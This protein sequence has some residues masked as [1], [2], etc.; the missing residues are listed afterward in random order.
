MGYRTEFEGLNVGTG[1]N[2]SSV[3]GNP[4]S[5]DNFRTFGLVKGI[6][7]SSMQIEGNGGKQ[8]VIGEGVIQIS[9]KGLGIIID[10]KF[11]IIDSHVPTLGVTKDI[12]TNGLGISVQECEIKHGDEKQDLDK[13][14]CSWFTAVIQR[15]YHTHYTPRLS[16]DHSTEYS[17]T[18][19]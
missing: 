14:S 2:R 4:Q 17:A 8:G 7:P 12:W 10:V 18:R 13:I 5:E 15:I 19:R 9:F 3:I 11:K 1:E 16:C 6:C